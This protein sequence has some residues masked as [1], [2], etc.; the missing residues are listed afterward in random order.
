[1]S[2]NF[3]SLYKKTTS[4]SVTYGAGGTYIVSNGVLMGSSQFLPAFF[5]NFSLSLAPVFFMII[6]S[7]LR[8]AAVYHPLRPAKWRRLV[9]FLN[10]VFFGAGCI[11]S[12]SFSHGI[13]HIHG[14]QRHKALIV[15][16]KMSLLGLNSILWVP[17]LVMVFPHLSFFRP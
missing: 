12:P 1:M 13:Q 3:T 6:A 2:V 8:F 10:I 4:F 14:G 7:C 16:P 5:A 9:L 17:M 11:S 15:F